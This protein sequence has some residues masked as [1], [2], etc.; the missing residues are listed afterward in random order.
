MQTSKRKKKSSRGRFVAKFA[1]NKSETVMITST[2]LV[3]CI[4]C[5]WSEISL[6][7]K[8]TTQPSNPVHHARFFFYDLSDHYEACLVHRSAGKRAGIESSLVPGDAIRTRKLKNVWEIHA[9][10]GPLDSLLA[11]SCCGHSR[12]PIECV[13]EWRSGCTVL[14]CE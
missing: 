3:S 8:S 12:K 13:V 10:F 5:T 11:A 6:P 9:A 2:G 14:S 4:S 1:V 7:S